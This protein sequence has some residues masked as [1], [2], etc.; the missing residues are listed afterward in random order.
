MPGV[1]LFCSLV[2]GDKICIRG[3]SVA[4]R[5]PA[6]DLGC[7]DLQQD[8]R[9]DTQITKDRFRQTLITAALVD[10]CRMSVKDDLVVECGFFPDSGYQECLV[11]VN[12]FDPLVSGLVGNRLR[13]LFLDKGACRK[14]RYVQAFCQFLA[15]RRLSCPVDTTNKD[16]SHHN[17]LFST[18]PGT[19]TARGR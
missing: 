6:Y 8:H 15:E 1:F 11:V 13:R 16:N 12:I 18:P 19:T 7:R 5:Q 14:M 9:C 17:L 10:D 4:Q 3:R 2:R